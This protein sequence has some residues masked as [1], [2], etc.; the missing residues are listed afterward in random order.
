MVARQL[1]TDT[2][3]RPPMDVLQAPMKKQ[4]EAFLEERGLLQGWR[5]SP[6]WDEEWPMLVRLVKDQFGKTPWMDACE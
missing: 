4:F 3:T 2:R 5:E 6:D 1:R